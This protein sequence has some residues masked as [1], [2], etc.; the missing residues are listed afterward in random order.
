M[1][2]ALLTTH[3][4]GDTP[5]SRGTH[6]TRPLTLA[7]THNPIADAPEKKRKRGKPTEGSEEGEI[8]QPIQQPPTKEPRVTKAQQKKGTAIWAG[9]G[10]E[11][12]QHSKAT[13]WNP[14]FI[15]SSRDPIKSEASIKGP[16]KGKS[17]LVSKCLEK[18]LLLPKD[19]QVLQGLRKHKVF[20]SLKRD[21]AKVSLHPST[22][23]QPFCVLFTK[24]ITHALTSFF[25]SYFEYKLCKRLSWPGSGWTMLC[26]NP[27]M[28]RVN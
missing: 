5:V 18:D 22:L 26:Q 13:I 4:G 21:L 6:C 24:T 28:Q 7:P 1:L 15:L 25:F 20:L 9:K 23:L 2:L 3:A 17:G 10:T 8:P 11:G 19:M 14:T 27:E 12:E 16:Q